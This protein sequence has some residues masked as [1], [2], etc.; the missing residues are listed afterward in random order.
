MPATKRRHRDYLK[1]TATRQ[2]TSPGTCRQPRFA[3]AKLIERAWALAGNSSEWD[4][5]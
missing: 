2:I 1:T 4:S 5:D 3:Q